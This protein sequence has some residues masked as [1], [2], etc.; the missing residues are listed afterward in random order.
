MRKSFNSAA[1]TVYSQSKLIKKEMESPCSRPEWC[2]TA[3]TINTITEY[4]SMV[5]ATEACNAHSV[6]CCIQH[7]G[8]Q[9]MCTLH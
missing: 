3:D 2:M 4:Q 8:F 9:Y 7:V 1:F 5:P 6:H